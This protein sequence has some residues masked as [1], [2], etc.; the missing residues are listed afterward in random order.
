[1]GTVRISDVSSR[2]VVPLDG[3]NVSAKVVTVE[4]TKFRIDADPSLESNTAEMVVPLV[5][6]VILA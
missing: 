4:E 2:L 6:T 5:V 1:M 3:M